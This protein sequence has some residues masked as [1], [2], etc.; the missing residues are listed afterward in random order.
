MLG[1]A[2]YDAVKP[3]GKDS[4][5]FCIAFPSGKYSGHRF[6]F[7]LFTKQDIDT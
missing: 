2:S 5:S 1:F 4:N 7:A 6:I 3:K